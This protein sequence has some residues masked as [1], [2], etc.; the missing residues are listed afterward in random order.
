MNEGVKQKTPDTSVGTFEPIR[1]RHQTGF[2]PTTQTGTRHSRE[3]H[4]R[5]L[6]HGSLYTNTQNARLSRPRS[7]ARRGALLLRGR[8]QPLSDH[9]DRRRAAGENARYTTHSQHGPS[10]ATHLL[11][12]GW[13]CCVCVQGGAEK[14]EESAPV[15]FRYRVEPSKRKVSHL[16]EAADSQAFCC[17]CCC[18]AIV[19]SP[20]SAR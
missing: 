7:V 17:C 12:C 3:K 14:E 20:A 11:L 6:H 19:W 8:T 9:E 10:I 5:T 13:P 18:S 1:P 15:A 16:L 2:A 4:C